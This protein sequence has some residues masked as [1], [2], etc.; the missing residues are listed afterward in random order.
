[1]E[2]AKCYHRR[3]D[4]R[5][6]TVSR[7]TEATRT[8]D[9]MFRRASELLTDVVV[10]RPC[11][12]KEL[13]SILTD[14][15]SSLPIKLVA[16]HGIN[17]ILGDMADLGDLMVF[18]D[19]TVTTDL[20]SSLMDI[21][22]SSE[23]HSHAALNLIHFC[24]L[25]NKG[26]SIVLGCSKLVEV[27]FGILISHRSCEYELLLSGLSLF[28]S[29]AATAKGGVLIAKARGLS[30]LLGD[31]LCLPMWEMRAAVVEL[32]EHVLF[33]PD[34]WNSAQ[35][36]HKLLTSMDTAL[37]NDQNWGPRGTQLRVQLQKQRDFIDCLNRISQG[38]GSEKAEP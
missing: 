5:S 36:S 3:T 19:N 30:D 13:F 21:V 11:N 32:L 8:P 34:G 17:R 26:M 16:I 35:G 4:D 2:H 18:V 37:K 28:V 27:V 29:L 33:C 23:P 9:E 20:V 31:F 15:A 38:F 6:K 22:A 12:L 25:S 1:M 7:Q 10:S 24:I 14:G